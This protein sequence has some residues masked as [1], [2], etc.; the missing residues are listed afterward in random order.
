MIIELKPSTR[1]I[2]LRSTSW[3]SCLQT[4]EIIDKL[5]QKI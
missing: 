2:P 1:E 4:N 3:F 5:F